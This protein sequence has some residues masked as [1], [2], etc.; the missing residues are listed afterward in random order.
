[1]YKIKGIGLI[2]L[3]FLL[4]ISSGYGQVSF[5]PKAGLNLATFMGEIHHTNTTFG[6]QAGVMADIRF[7]NVFGLQ[8]SLTLTMKGSNKSVNIRDETHDTTFQTNY[9]EI[10]VHIFYGFDMQDVQ[11]LIFAGPYFGY[12]LW[13]SVTA[14]EK[15]LQSEKETTTQD[16]Q[17]VSDKTE[18]E[19]GSY[20]FSDIDAGFNIGIGFRNYPIQLKGAYSL[21]L[22]NIVPP[23]DHQKAERFIQNSVVQLTVTYFMGPDPIQRY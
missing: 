10:P 19:P 7:S 6:A 12:G 22:K 20:P 17:F 23:D 16:V 21:G 3:V 5:G 13:G 4:L 1:M 18:S 14:T 15:S 11:V 2:C 9:L 8:P